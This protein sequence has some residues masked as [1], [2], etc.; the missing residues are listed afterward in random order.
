LRLFR[1]GGSNKKQQEQQQL[2][3]QFTYEIGK[4]GKNEGQ[5]MR[6]DS[7]FFLRAIDPTS[8]MMMMIIIRGSIMARPSCQQQSWAINVQS[9]VTYSV[10]TNCTHLV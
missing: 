10:Q 3:Q 7:N 4:R 6:K 9:K 2:A 1:S 5:L 8:I